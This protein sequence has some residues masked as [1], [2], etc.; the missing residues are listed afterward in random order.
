MISKEQSELALKDQE[1]RMTH[2]IQLIRL[3]VEEARNLVA[4]LQKQKSRQEEGY[5]EQ[6]QALINELL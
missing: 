4:L 3:Q 5:F 1:M 2:E 6:K